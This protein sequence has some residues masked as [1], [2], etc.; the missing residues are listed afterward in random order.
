MEAALSLYMLCVL[1]SLH[2][3]TTTAQPPQ[4]PCDSYLRLYYPEYFTHCD[5]AYIT[6]WSEWEMMD[7]STVTVPLDQCPSGQA[8]SEIRRQVAIGE[9]CVDKTETRLVCK[10]ECIS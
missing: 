6:D 8:Y 3:H 2:M 7:N 4:A 9:G 10:F 5:C 1:C